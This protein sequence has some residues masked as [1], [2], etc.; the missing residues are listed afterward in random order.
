MVLLLQSRILLKELLDEKLRA[1]RLATGDLTP[2]EI[3]HILTKQ[4]DDDIDDFELV[5][6]MQKLR[7]ELLKQVRKNSILTN[8]QKK[9]DNKIGL[10]IQN[11]TSIHE[12]DREEKKK[13]KKN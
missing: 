13:E 6:R 10:L 3:K 11:R 2:Y 4:G 12:I 5:N 8:E 9:I 7:E 1:A